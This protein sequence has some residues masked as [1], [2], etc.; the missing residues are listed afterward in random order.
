MISSRRDELHVEVVVAR[1][2]SG[3]TANKPRKMQCLEKSGISMS[4][5][6]HKITFRCIPFCYFQSSLIYLVMPS[7]GQQSAYHYLS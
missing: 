7:I 1:T 2:S 5:I 3:T 6:I 4:E